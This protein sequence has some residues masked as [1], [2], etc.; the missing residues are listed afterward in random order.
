MHV[1]CGVSDIYAIFSQLIPQIYDVSLQLLYVLFPPFLT[2]LKF[3]N[4]IGCV[5]MLVYLLN[6]VPVRV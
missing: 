2:I 3:E 4:A 1:E 5:V 6:E